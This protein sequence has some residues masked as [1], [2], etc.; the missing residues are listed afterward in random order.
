M[1]STQPIA[2]YPP[3]HGGSSHKP[4]LVGI[5]LALLLGSVVGM[6]LLLAGSW[7][8]CH[9]ELPLYAASPIAMSAISIATAVSGMVLAGLQKKNGLLLG[10]S[11]GLFFLLAFTAAAILMG[12]KTFSAFSAIK[13]VCLMTSGALGGYLGMALSERK[14]MRY[15]HSAMQ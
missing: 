11:C 13:L 5:T 12:A 9:T 14:P 8:L 3:S 2:T 10:A 7:L 15:R 6:A 4:L 1:I